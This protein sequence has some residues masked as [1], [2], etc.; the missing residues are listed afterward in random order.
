MAC[1][2]LADQ[3]RSAE[4]QM[5]SLKLEVDNKAANSRSSWKA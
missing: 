4:R 5:A 2:H 3:L 1:F